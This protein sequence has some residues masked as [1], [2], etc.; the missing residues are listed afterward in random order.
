VGEA[1]AKRRPKT[2]PFRRMGGLQWVLSPREVT[3]LLGISP[4]TLARI[5]DE[6]PPRVQITKRRYGWPEDKRLSRLSSCRK[7]IRPLAL[8]FRHPRASRLVAEG[9]VISMPAG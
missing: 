4:S 5:K 7:L 3:Q 6:L 1:D 2:C 9:P 8:P